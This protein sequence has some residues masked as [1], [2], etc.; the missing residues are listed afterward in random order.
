MYTQCFG[1]HPNCAVKKEEDFD[2][3]SLIGHKILFFFLYLADAATAVA[4]SKSP[5]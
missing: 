5:E 3:F 4:Y 1:H 2:C